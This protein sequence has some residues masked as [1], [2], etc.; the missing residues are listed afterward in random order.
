MS[1]ASRAWLVVIVLVVLIL[2]LRAQSKQ[3]L[4]SKPFFDGERPLVI[5]HRGGAILR[6]EN[7]LLAFRHAQRIGVDVLEMDVR[8]SRDGVLVVLH[9]ED[10]ARTTNGKGK[11]H[12]LDYAAL[13]QLD[14]AYHWL[15]A[16]AGD[17]SQPPFRGDGVTIPRFESVLQEFTAIR[18]NIEIKQHDEV[19]AHELCRLL[20]QYRAEQRTL[21][22]TE[23]GATIRA[24]REACPAVATATARSE[25][26]GFLLNQKFRLL[27]FYHP[28]AYALEL[29]RK[30]HGL[31]LINHR[32]V[33]DARAQGMHVLPWT[34]NTRQGMRELLAMGVSGIITD[35]PN[36]LLAEL[37]ERQE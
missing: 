3:V 31:S 18:L 5:A 13:Q 8:A 1:R 35:A 7:T 32:M 27:G 12:S 23:D 22:A 20:R 24:F 34:I 30:Y 33:N 10:V 25:S 9:D 29:P 15:P 2:G 14:A 4:E 21:V 36:L 26:V 28:R 11:V 16:E 19:V 37:A 17:H 6:P